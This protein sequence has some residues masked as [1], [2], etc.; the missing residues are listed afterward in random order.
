[1]RFSEFF[2]GIELVE[3]HKF[4]TDQDVKQAGVEAMSQNAYI[5]AA[6]R[7]ILS[8]SIPFNTTEPSKGT[9][10]LDKPVLTFHVGDHWDSKPVGGE[11]SKMYVR[12]I[13][14]FM[15]DPRMLKNMPKGYADGIRSI[16]RVFY[17]PD[18]EKGITVDGR[19]YGPRLLMAVLAHELVHLSDPAIAKVRDDYFA[20]NQD[21]FSS[22]DNWNHFWNDSSVEPREKGGNDMTAADFAKYHD[23]D[24][25]RKAMYGGFGY[26]MADRLAGDHV[27][28]RAAAMDRLRRMGLEDYAGMN[29][30]AHTSRLA[31]NHYEK[32]PEHADKIKRAAFDYLDKMMPIKPA[33]DRVGRGAEYYARLKATNP[34]AYRALLAK[35]RSGRSDDRPRRTW[36]GRLLGR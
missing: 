10:V 20:N 14:T 12:R 6:H 31:L 24:R 7:A 27:G 11:G 17:N 18:A 9:L 13:R 33:E 26:E 16:L 4:T 23:T 25:E 22:G 35:A 2:S 30:T 15:Y 29:Q 28:D 34:K 36:L 3:S 32:N 8:G 5:R 1:M 19:P 21:Y